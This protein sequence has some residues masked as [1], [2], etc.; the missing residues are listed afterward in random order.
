MGTL[1]TNKK[2][3]AQNSLLLYVRMFITMLMG[4]I[5]SRL[6]LDA[7]GV[8]DYGIYNVVG[9]VTSMFVFLNTTM[10]VATSRFIAFAI[11]ENNKKKLCTIYNQAR[12]IHY[13]I[14]LLV[15]VLIESFG[16]WMVYNKLNLPYDRV[17]ASILV[18]HSVSVVTIL[19]IMSTPDMALIIAYER[20]KSFAYISI[21][22]STM[23]LLA[24]IVLVFFS[25]DKL[26][27]YAILVTM[28]QVVDRIFYLVY[29]RRNFEEAK[30][31]LRFD[32]PVFRKMFSFAGWN[33]IGGSASL[34]KDQGV[35]IL[36]NL[37]IGPV[38]NAARGIANTVN[39]VLA[40]FASN[41]MT[42]LKP[43][44]TKSYA[45]GDYGYMV[46]LVERG[47]R[48]SYYILLLFALPMLFETEFVLTLWL[49]HYPEHTV[50]FVRLILIVTMCDIL[51]NTL[52]ILKAATGNVR[53]Y[54]I[55]VGGMLLMNFPLSY[56]C[57]KVDFPPEST[58]VVALLVS[59][60]CLIL[61]LL[62]LR[63]I[64][65]F[66]M[67][68]YLCKVCGNVLIVTF[69]SMILP[70]LL[71]K[72]M[73]DG[74]VRFFLICVLTTL[75]SSAAIY[76]VGCNKNEQMFIREKVTLIRRKIF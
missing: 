5:T 72:Q 12:I 53:N 45:A 56:F 11:G 2:R 51:S 18:L 60:F 7:L 25:G 3:I 10:S 71:Y 33:F 69:I 46:S 68:R 75:C 13:G 6:V 4:L 44:I 9:G 34:L 28:I 67:K 23:K 27:F 66:S 65:G 50:N 1:E 63:K 29:C 19:N 61:R 22:D 58:L 55:V 37:F 35:N 59:I 43:Q 52:I 32:R 74:I 42:A 36:L 21:F 62:F 48:F 20:M 57:L 47:S 76:F 30:C 26:I 40:S 49:K 31:K 70:L 41:F 14:G 24:T 73:S 17:T 16:Q 64:P 38:I 39:N 8:I 15:L 54:Q